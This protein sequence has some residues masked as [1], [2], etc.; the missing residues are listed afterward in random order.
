MVACLVGKLIARSVGKLAAV[1]STPAIAG[2]TPWQRSAG[3]ADLLSNLIADQPL[4]RH[5][6]CRNRDTWPTFDAAMTP[7]NVVAQDK[8]SRI[9]A[10]CPRVERCAQW[11]LSLPP[12]QRP[13]ETWPWS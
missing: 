12:A 6:A 1:E 13:D 2:D 7:S 9:C 8:A 4:M 3:P 5:A 11:V 10:R